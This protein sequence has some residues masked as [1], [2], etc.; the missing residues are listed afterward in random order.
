MGSFGFEYKFDLSEQLRTNFRYNYT[1]AVLG[2]SDSN[3]PRGRRISIITRVAP[4]PVLNESKSLFDSFG[5]L[6][7][8][9]DSENYFEEK[10]PPTLPPL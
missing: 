8:I 7:E 10:K 4:D 1:H 2:Q 9:D 6:D 5:T 3:I